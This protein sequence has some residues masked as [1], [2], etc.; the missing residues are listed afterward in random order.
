MK[1]ELGRN[2]DP[3]YVKRVK[4]FIGSS[5]FT[6]TETVDNR[7]EINKVDDSGK[8]DGILVSPRY[9]NQIEIF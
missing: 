7:L 3:K 1:V 8:N 9:S 5:K 2:E 6:L 4:I